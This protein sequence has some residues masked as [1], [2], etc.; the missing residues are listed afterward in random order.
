M[1]KFSTIAGAAIAATGIVCLIGTAS[2]AELT[3][4]EIKELVSGKSVYVDFTE[5]STGGAGKGVIYYAA[6][7]TALYKRAG[8]G[9]WHGTWSVKD[10]TTCT[11]WKESPNNGCSKYNKQ[12]DTIT[13]INVTTGKSRGTVLK[14]AAGN[15]EKI[16][17]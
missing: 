11:D 12:G 4:A 3:G 7:G 15:A 10:N 8:G 16:A 17:Q 2:A 1:I 6:D 5:A 13:Q 14:T 9:I